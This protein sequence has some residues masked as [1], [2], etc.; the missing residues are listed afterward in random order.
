MTRVLQLRR[1]TTA[2][3]DAFT[4]MAGEI[5]MD[6]EKKT[7]RIHDGETLGGFEF[8]RDGH[9]FDINSVSD[10]FWNKI[11]TDFTPTEMKI[12]ESE[13]LPVNS[14]ANGTEYTFDIHSTP[15]TIDVCL[16]CV[17][18]DAGYAT[19]DCVR[20][21]GVGQ[22][23]ATM[24]NYTL[25]EYGLNVQFLTGFEKYWVR[26]KETGAKTNIDDENWNILFRVYY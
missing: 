14:N 26:H 2:Q 6:I 24:P 10:E 19:S 5:T 13:P 1:G 22:M 9:T 23:N 18:N 8:V 15:K 3:N 4:G 17:N 16:V 7:I 25:D 12:I 20:A 11:V 21:F